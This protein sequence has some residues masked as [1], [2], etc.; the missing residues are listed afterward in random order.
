[1]IAQTLAH[2]QSAL[3]AVNEPARMAQAP[4]DHATNP[5]EN[6]ADDP[7][8]NP[9]KKP[10]RKKLTG[11]QK[12]ERIAELEVQLALGTPEQALKAVAD[13]K[14]AH[15]RLRSMRYHM[16]CTERCVTRL[17]TE[18]ENTELGNLRDTLRHVLWYP[19]DT[20]DHALEHN[21]DQSQQL[22]MQARIVLDQEA[23]IHAIN[24]ENRQL[25]ARIVELEDE[26]QDAFDQAPHIRELEQQLA[27]RDKQIRAFE[28]L[29]ADTYWHEKYA[30]LLDW[31]KNLFANRSIPL[32]C[33]LV[34]W[35][36]YMM[37]SLL[38]AKPTGE[39]VRISVEET[40]AN[41]GIS[42][43]T[44]R[45]A[46]DKALAFDVLQR[47]YEPIER[48]NG[49]KLTLMHIRLNNVVDRPELIEM[50][51]VHGGAR[52]KK[53]PKCKSEDIDRYTVQ[54]CRECQTT[55]WYGQPGIRSDAN[56]LD[57]QRS[58][59]EQTPMVHSAID[60]NRKQDAFEPEPETI[61]PTEVRI[62]SDPVDQA[63]AISSP[64]TEPERNIL[65][66]SGG[67]TIDQQPQEQDA[68]EPDDTPTYRG[69]NNPQQKPWRCRTS[70]CTSTRFRWINALQD[71]WCLECNARQMPPVRS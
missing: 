48:D 63:P 26:K 36:F 33:K 23:T 51:N 70:C 6:P 28:Q 30:G 52:T 24:D 25:R 14:A 59:A 68:F 45:R 53:C 10:Y 38:R 67:E 22:A 13:L 17:A 66:T 5:A 27:E 18:L 58:V 62:N 20:P 12:D 60:P 35:Q 61:N 44:V 56:V 55:A 9:A 37:I 40:A 7:T 57:A 65:E 4:V 15:F 49:D 39:E 3:A 47:R 29:G 54:Y 11:K 43:S 42:K 64:T 1:M 34:I 19:Q 32:A 41:L 8:E 31:S 2:T 50:D 69:C 21:D 46:A 71:W 16:D